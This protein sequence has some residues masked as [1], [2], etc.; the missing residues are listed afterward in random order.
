M[1]NNEIIQ[2]AAMVLIAGVLLYRKYVRK[3]KTGRR[4]DR[5]VTGRSLSSS[6]SQDD[7]YEPYLKKDIRN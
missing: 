3:K 7:D 2:I 6:Q 5:K 1:K 4:S